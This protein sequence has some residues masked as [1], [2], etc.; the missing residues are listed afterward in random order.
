MLRDVFLIKTTT[1]TEISFHNVLEQLEKGLRVQVARN[2]QTDS[3]E[4]L[5]LFYCCLSIILITID[6]WKCLYLWVYYT[7]RS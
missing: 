1:E 2:L 7:M 3:T 6:W 4:F 5:L